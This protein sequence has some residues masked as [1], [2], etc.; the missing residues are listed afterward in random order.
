M[1]RSHSRPNGRLYCGGCAR[2]NGGRH[3]KNFICRR[4]VFLK[5]FGRISAAGLFRSIAVFLLGIVTVLALAFAV[6]GYERDGVY[7]YTT[8]FDY[9]QF[10]ELAGTQLIC[11]IVCILLL[12]VGALAAVFAVIALLL[13]GK[14][15]RRLTDACGVL[16]VVFLCAYMV[17]G[18]VVCGEQETMRDDAALSYSTALYIPFA[19]GAALLVLYFA[20]GIPLALRGKKKAQRAAE[21][22]SAESASA[23]P[24]VAAP[25]ATPAAVS[26]APTVATAAPVA[27]AAP[28]VMAAGSAAV[29][30]RVQNVPDAPAAEEKA[31][32]VR[33][34]EEPAK[35]RAVPVSRME[36]VRYLEGIVPT[37]LS[38][39]ELYDGGVLTEE[40]FRSF[41]SLLLWEN[42]RCSGMPLRP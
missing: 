1:R 29:Q 42:C 18:F 37:L 34:A 3:E 17:I 13:K 24:V 21:G 20:V 35:S 30:G 7:Y 27:S 23:E 4:K 15:A 22:S 28:A 36:R 19:I 9:L 12:A 11:A 41:R 8:G 38:Y 40:E 25:V 5:K 14:G 10:N 31:G 39:K 6:Y 16:C 26:A 2:N 32:S 33:P